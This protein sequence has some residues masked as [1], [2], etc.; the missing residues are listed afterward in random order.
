[1]FAVFT[2]SLSGFGL[3]LVS[4]SLITLIADLDL[5]ESVP[6]VALVAITTQ[7][8][9]LLYLRRSLLFGSI[10]RLGIGAIFGVPFGL[11]AVKFGNRGVLLIMLGVI[12]TAYA[13]YSLLQLPLGRMKNKNLGYL[14]G[15]IGGFLGAC[16][17]TSGPPVVIYGTASRW[18]PDEFRATLQ[19]FFIVQATC[20]IFGHFLI[21]NYTALV[22]TRYARTL[23]MIAVGIVAGLVLSRRINAKTFRRIVLILLVI[24][25]AAQIFNGVRAVRGPERSVVQEAPNA[26]D[27][28]EESPVA[29]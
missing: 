20:T 27:V 13:L 4:M 29:E 22:L 23:P 15:S 8:V 9:L 12:A 14:F 11:Y 6:L 7:V 25:G 21:G 24:V 16:L 10:R 26:L 2:Q 3:G 19:G 28:S 17:S 5:N 18:K 1:L